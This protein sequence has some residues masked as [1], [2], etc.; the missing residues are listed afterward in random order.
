MNI[1]YFRFLLTLAAFLYIGS[2]HA[3]TSCVPYSATPS[4]TGGSSAAWGTGL[5]GSNCATGQVCDSAVLV[6]VFPH[7]TACSASVPCSIGKRCVTGICQDISGSTA[8]NNV[9]GDVICNTYKFATG[10]V[11]RGIVVVIIFVTGV[12]FYLG[13]ISWGSILMILIGVGFC[14]G[15]PA[16]VGIILGRGFM[17]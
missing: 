2:A 6:C 4:A 15:G 8:E 10:K 3:A 7:E 11:G 14:F 13:K 5:D 16:I 9:I 17:C 12:M 1:G